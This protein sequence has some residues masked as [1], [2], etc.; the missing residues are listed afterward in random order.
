MSDAEVFDLAVI[1]AGIVGAATARAFQQQ[2]PGS[3][4]ALLE[5]EA[6]PAQHQTSHNSGVIHAGVYYK[7]GSLKASL[8][9]EGHRRMVSFCEQHEIPYR[10][11]GKL[12]VAVDDSELERLETL[13][14]RAIANGVANITK[15]DQAGL[16]DVEPH[17]AGI[18]ALHIRATA[19]TDYEAVTKQ[20]VENL[21]HDGADVL[22]DF[23][24]SSIVRELGTVII[25]ARS[26]QIVR[27]QRVVA[28]TGTQADR[29][30]R[31]LQEDPDFSVLPFR[32]AYYD[33]KPEAA[34]RVRSM[35]Y[36][37]PDPRFPF[38]GVH[39]TRHIDDTVSCGPNAVL[40]PARSGGRRLA[41]TPR[42]L[43][44]AARFRGTWKLAQKYWRECLVELM[45]DVSKQRFAKAAARYLPDLEAVDLT[46][47]HFGIRAQAV[48]R[49]GDLIDDFDFRRVGPVLFVRNAPSPAATAGLAIADHILN[50]LEHSD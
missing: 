25:Q 26:G 39:F 11:S 30:Q 14:Q 36:P 19:I 41:V 47:Y 9:I 12:I 24:A 31:M 17:A 23:D 33:L 16:R 13:R 6:R 27:A 28:C 15:L 46:D 2:H 5:K 22:F 38:L 42:D 48:K 21:R 10:T 43:F 37:V 20:L 3:R 35:I 4:V 7:P 29:T 45:H 50:E 32:G 49:S 34:A 1:G 18:A 44:D 40:S 8:C